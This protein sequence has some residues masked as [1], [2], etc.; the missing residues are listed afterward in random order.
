VNVLVGG[1][2]TSSA[3]DQAL[4]W[5]SS[6]TNTMKNQ[7][8]VSDAPHALPSVQDGALRVVS[9]IQNFCKAPV[10]LSTK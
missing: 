7:A 5:E 8:C 4:T 2:D 3:V 6:L 9:D 1:Q 10:K